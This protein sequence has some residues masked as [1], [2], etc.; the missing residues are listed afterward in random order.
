MWFVVIVAFLSLFIY[1][2]VFTIRFSGMFENVCCGIAYNWLFIVCFYGFVVNCF[3]CCLGW[4]FVFVVLGF[5]FLVLV[6]VWYD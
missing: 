4:F 2:V 1:L 5:C 3:T 6:V